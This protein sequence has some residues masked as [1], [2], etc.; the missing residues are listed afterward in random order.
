M[1]PEQAACQRFRFL[2]MCRV[3]SRYVTHLVVDP[4]Q[5]RR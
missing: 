1:E 3:I 2:A 5:V 4:D